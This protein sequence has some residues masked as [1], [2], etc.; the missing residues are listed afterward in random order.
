M[1]SKG[2]NPI[3]VAQG[4]ENI[5]LLTLNGRTFRKRA[6]DGPSTASLA[7]F[8]PS[9]TD[10][11][12]CDEPCDLDIR[13]EKKGGYSLKMHV[14]PCFYPF[15]IGKKGNTKQRIE[16]E[17]G[18]SLTIGQDSSKEPITIKGPAKNSIINA[19]TRLEIIIETASKT[20]PYTHF[21]SI[22]LNLPSVIENATK[23]NEDLIQECEKK[24]VQGFDP[25]LLQQ[26][27]QLHMTIVMLKL[28]DEIAV[29]KTKVLLSSLAP[30]IYDVLG[31]RSLHVHLQDLDI[32]NDDPSDAKVIHLKV[33]TAENDDRLAKLCEFL[34][35]SF[36]NA[37]LLDETQDREVKLHVTLLNVRFRAQTSLPQPLDAKPIL[38][39]Y[40]KLDFGDVKLPAL[41][42]SERGKFDSDGYYHCVMKIDYP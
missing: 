42:L 27:T 14:A 21:L 13:T 34:V 22:P 24:K 15:I 38:S 3:K 40:G 10:Q 35:S 19:H 25:S 12:E 5:Q 28:F 9:R 2:K 16:K 23:F 20:L 37:G 30:K 11:E 39:M 29:N 7:D 33:K 31:T 4:E 26:P 1:A 41:H 18:T 17:T 32:M 8:L 6:V 36:K